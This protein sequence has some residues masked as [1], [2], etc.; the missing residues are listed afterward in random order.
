MIDCGPPPDAVN[1]IRIYELTF[2]EETA[3]YQC[4][5][6]YGFE[7]GSTEITITCLATGEWSEDVPQ[8]LSE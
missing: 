5:E 4:E 1:G 2:L 3:S 6:N 7:D 8:C